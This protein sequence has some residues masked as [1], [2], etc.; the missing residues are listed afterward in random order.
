[1]IRDDRG[2]ESDI[3]KRLLDRPLETKCAMEGVHH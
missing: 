3:L 1:M 2:K